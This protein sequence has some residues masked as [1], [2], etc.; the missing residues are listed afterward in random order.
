MHMHVLYTTQLHLYIHVS[1]YLNALIYCGVLLHNHMLGC[2]YC[3]TSSPHNAMHSSSFLTGNPCTGGKIFRQCG[4]VCPETCDSST[5]CNISGCAE[6]CFCPDGQVENSD[7][8]CS[9]C[10]SKLCKHTYVRMYTHT[11]SYTVP[12]ILNLTHACVCTR[13]CT[14]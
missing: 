9:N 14:R 3:D 7:G 8:S 6:G 1:M 4:P 11:Y 2:N 10:K 13:A 12:L 5:A